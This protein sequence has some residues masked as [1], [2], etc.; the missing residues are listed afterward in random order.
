MAVQAEVTRKKCGEI[1][2]FPGDTFSLICDFC[3]DS[4]FALEAL[5]AHLSAHFPKSPTNI[6]TEDN[7]DS[8]SD[9]E[10]L[11]LDI[12]ED[13]MEKLV[14]NRKTQPTAADSIKLDAI[15]ETKHYE[16]VQASCDLSNI[17][18]DNANTQSESLLIEQPD[19]TNQ[20][21]IRSEQNE[22]SDVAIKR[23]TTTTRNR[24]H[25]TVKLVRQQ[26]N[27][28]DDQ[29]ILKC[30]FKCRLCS[31][32]FRYQSVLK[33]HHEK[34]HP[35]KRPYK[36]KL[37]SKTFTHKYTLSNHTKAL[38]TNCRP[39]QC[40]TCPKRF[41]NKGHLDVHTR[42]KHLPDTDPR[43]YFPCKL[44]V[45]KFKSQRSL[46]YHKSRIH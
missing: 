21:N 17:N 4:C 11:P 10:S 41:I 39:Y 24:G 18:N 38:H 33:R 9:C 44:C 27:T 26:T 20:Q 37:C 12:K 19:P 16:G 36:C 30:N 22:G 8:S 31:R 32:F 23:C 1:F 28:N 5:R 13:M 34:V 46:S 14:V 25:D 29:K 6:K 2:I 3:G 15:Y 45:E 43:R 40:L 35:D 7:F 42:E